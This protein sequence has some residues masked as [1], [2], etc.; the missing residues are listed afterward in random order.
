MMYFVAPVMTGRAMDIAGMLGSMM[1]GSWA[2]GM[3]T[4][5]ANGVL[6]FALIYAFVVSPILPGPP[7]FRG[8]LWGGILWMLVEMVVMPLTG[9]GFFSAHAGG[10]GSVIAALLGHLVY[11]VALGAVAGAPK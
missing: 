8:L 9:A 5:I 11:G 10:T 3:T 4:H 7:W 2:L 6:V 1:G